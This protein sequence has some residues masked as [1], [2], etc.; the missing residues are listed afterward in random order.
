M[1]IAA[2]LSASW[3]ESS[4]PLNISEE[5]L[6]KIVPLLL[7]SGAGALGWWRVRRSDLK[8]AEAAR[9]LHQA[10]RLHTLQAE[11]H[12]HEIKQAVALLRSYGIE[13]ILI[14]GWSVARLYAERGLRPYGDIDLIV[15]PEQMPKAE[16]ILKDGGL[17]FYVDVGHDE[18]EDLDA[19]RWDEL[20]D[21]TQ[22]LSLDETDVRVLCAEDELKLLCV[23]LLRH[24]AWRPLWLCDVGAALEAAST[25]FD[26]D[27]CLGSKRPQVNWITCAV[28]LAERLLA[29]N[30]VGF[31]MLERARR[32]PAW[33]VKNVLKQ[34][35]TPYAWKQAP[36]RYGAPVASYLR[37]PSGV[38]KDLINRWPNPIEATVSMEGEFNHLPRLP[39]QL[40]NCFSRTAKFVSH[41]PNLMREQHG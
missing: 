15:R 31:P 30:I 40:G 3:R 20:Y 16:E 8:E 34:W 13:P 14:K 2:S 19:Q 7:G 9:E 24:G 18:F 37:N 4:A 32:V 38:V 27:Y 11:M 36:I 12:Q 28:G 33:L 25:A 23:H 1:L 26:W 22:L 21:R 35:E 29:A 17:K 41:L 6:S 39:F 10:Y 5:E